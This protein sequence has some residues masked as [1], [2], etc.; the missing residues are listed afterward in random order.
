MKPIL[1]DLPVPIITPRLLL[2]PPQPGD[3]I[4]LNAAVS[5]SYDNIRHTMPWAKERPSD[6][7]L[8]GA[9]GYHHVIWE[10]PCL[11]TGYWI[12]TRYSGKGYMTEAVNAITQYAIK[13]LKMKRVAI[14]CDIDNVRSKKIPQRLGF[15]LEGTLKAH[16]LKP[17][18]DEVSDTVILTLFH[19]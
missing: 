16:R 14:T 1:L 12:R 17:L 4:A 9:T 3:G 18:T 8:I 6:N 7:I 15:Q 13:Q 19:L 2:R 11:E 5:E 10:V